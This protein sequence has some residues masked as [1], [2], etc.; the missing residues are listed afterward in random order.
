MPEPAL[1]TA[2]ATLRGAVDDPSR[3]LPEELFL[4]ASSILPLVC[5]DILFHDEH[6]RSLLTWRDDGLIPAG[7]HIPGG[8]MRHGETIAHRFREVARLELGLDATCPA[9]PDAVTEFH[10]PMPGRVRSHAIGMLFVCR[11]PGQPRADL[12]HDGGPP[13]PGAWAWHDGAPADLI[14]VHDVY[15]PRLGRRQEAQHG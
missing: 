12:R 8:V 9:T 14:E 10:R 7:W 1:A 4:Y 13:R 6:G 11:C 5:V 3:G 15:R 2:I